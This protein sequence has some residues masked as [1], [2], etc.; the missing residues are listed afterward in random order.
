MAA[1]IVQRP[2]PES[3]TRPPNFDSSGSSS[4]GAADLL[5]PRDARRRLHRR[6][7]RGEDRVEVLDHLRLAADHLAV[8][9]LQAPDAAA[10]A[11]IDIM[12]ALRLQLGGAA[13][14]VDV[15]RVAAVDDD[16]PLL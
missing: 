3:D 16:V 6:R 8:A 13:D 1:L 2:S 12:Q 14:V 11:D 7:Q 9:A 5:A 15:V 4:R 10:G